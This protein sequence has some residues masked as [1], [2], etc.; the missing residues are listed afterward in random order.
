MKHGAAARRCWIHAAVLLRGDLFLC[1]IDNPT[2][3]VSRPQEEPAPIPFA[4]CVG[5]SR[6]V[7]EGRKAEGVLH[8]DGIGASL[9]PNFPFNP[10]QWGIWEWKE[11]DRGMVVRFLHGKL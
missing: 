4:R 3:R 2:D 8:D 5:K 1:R 6:Y 7:F 11:R 10:F 9:S